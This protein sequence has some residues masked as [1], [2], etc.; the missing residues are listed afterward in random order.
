MLTTD[1]L[2]K[3]GFQLASIC[4]L[5]QKDEETLEHLLIHCPALGPLGSPHFLTKNGLGL[6]PP[7]KRLDIRMDNLSNK[8]ENKKTLEGNPPVFFRQSRRK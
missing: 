4:P 8:K 1:Q 3:R 6:P 5:C 2:K 7:R